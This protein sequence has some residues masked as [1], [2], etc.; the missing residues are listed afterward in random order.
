MRWL[1]RN[2]TDHAHRKNRKQYILCCLLVIV[3]LSSVVVFEWKKIRIKRRYFYKVLF[4]LVNI[5]FR[6][7][8]ILIFWRERGS[9]EKY[10]GTNMHD[11]RTKGRRC[12]NND[13]KRMYFL[14]CP[15]PRRSEKSDNSNKWTHLFYFTERNLFKLS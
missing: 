7:E 3:R 13:F 1:T 10:W 9:K 8:N 15:L 14:N 11:A 4:T 12:Q 5:V 2:A 6:I